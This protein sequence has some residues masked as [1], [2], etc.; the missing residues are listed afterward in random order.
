MIRLLFFSAFTVLHLHKLC[1]GL[2]FLLHWAALA[3]N[4][5]EE[6]KAAIDIPSTSKNFRINRDEAPING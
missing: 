4:N 2:G 3:S 6:R 1:L 5:A